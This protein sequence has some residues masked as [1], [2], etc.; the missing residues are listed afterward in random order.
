V[1][2][3]GR[4]VVRVDG[5]AEFLVDADG[6]RIGGWRRGSGPPVVLVHGGPGLSD[7]LE[8]LTEELSDGYTTYR[9]QQR[10]LEPS[11]D[12]GPF[13]I[14]QHVRDAVAVIDHI[15][16]DKVLL[17]GHS[18]GGHLAMHLAVSHPE[19]LRGVVI[20][21]PLGAVGDG[22]EAEMSE[23]LSA[24]VTSDDM[25]RANE[26]DQVAMRGEG[27]AG[28]AIEGLRLVWPG[29]FAD[30]SKAPPM[31]PLKMSL[32][33]YSETWESIHHHLANRSLE[34]T[35]PDVRLPTVFVLGAE[36]PLP[37]SNAQAS[38]KVIPGASVRI[39]DGA[40]H[41]PWLEKPGVV[42]DALDSLVEGSQ[43]D[44]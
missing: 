10:G 20:V 32:P 13:S 37:V 34:M 35:L 6:S 1:C 43:P 39:V 40:G 21:D 27:T 14:E 41:F 18:W 36:S 29:Y 22:G 33:C 30:P 23:R 44:P 5:D 2:T 16:Q 28:D 19:R 25:A 17:I 4:K 38:A 31:P 11:S 12:H 26:L 9:Y 24:R 7:Y 42:R 3:E 8:S 15:A